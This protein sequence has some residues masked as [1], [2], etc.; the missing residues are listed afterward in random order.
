MGELAHL[1]VTLIYQ[2]TAWRRVRSAEK[3]PHNKCCKYILR[4]ITHGKYFFFL[5]SVL[6]D[7]TKVQ[8]VGHKYIL[9]AI[10]TF[11]EFIL[12]IPHS[13]YLPY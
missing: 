13:K 7:T 11:L 9:C 5:S 1:I 3:E 2:I 10:T 8:T 12:Y 4:A 6:S